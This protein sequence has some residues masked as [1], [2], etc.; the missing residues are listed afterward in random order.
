MPPALATLYVMSPKRKTQP[1]SRVARALRARRGYVGKTLEQIADESGGLLNTRML[2][3]L[4]TGKRDIND[5]PLSRLNMLLDI[6][7]WSGDDFSRETGVNVPTASAIPGSADYVPTL[8]LP[9]FGSVSA[10]IA[11]NWEPDPDA[12]PLRVDKNLSWLRGRDVTRLV[13]V[14]VNGD[15]M[16]SPN[17]AESIPHG[18]KLIVEVG[19][20]PADGDF[21][22][23]WIDDLG[24]SV[25]KKFSEGSDTVLKSLNPR[26]PVFRAHEHKIDVRGVVRFIMLKPA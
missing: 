5:L 18:S 1:D 26:G 8:E 24:V 15:S 25:V 19:A 9:Q 16:V 13:T 3:E 11:Q 23:A 14:D 4:Q 17:A 6:L 7:E 10:G 20:A 22:I 12:P 2:S 21:V